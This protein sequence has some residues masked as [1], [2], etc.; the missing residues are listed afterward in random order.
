MGPIPPSPRAR[1]RTMWS[2]Y[3]CTLG[4]QRQACLWGSGTRQ[5]SPDPKNKMDGSRG[6]TPKEPTHMS[7]HTDIRTHVCVH[8][9]AHFRVGNFT[10]LS[11][12]DE[13]SRWNVSQGTV[14]LNR[15]CQPDVTDQLDP[16]TT[17][18]QKQYAHTS[19][20]HG[21]HSSLQVIRCALTECGK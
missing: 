20:T 13:C 7:R 12:M 3:A 14:E 18:S 5:D 21:K 19:T 9:H 8:A 10:L 17:S 11:D 16:R 2:P 15:A 6:A 1:H 4:R